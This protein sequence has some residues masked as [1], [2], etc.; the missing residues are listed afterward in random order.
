MEAIGCP[1]PV[2]QQRFDD[3]KGHFG[4]SE[5]CWPEHR[6]VGQADGRAKYL[7]PQFRRGRSLEQILL[8]EKDRADRLGALGLGVTRWGWEIGSHAEAL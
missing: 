2:L 1:R 3:Y 6:L 7:S 8:D 4:F 5:F